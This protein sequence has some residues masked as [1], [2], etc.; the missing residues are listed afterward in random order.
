MAERG[1]TASLLSELGVEDLYGFLGVQS[2]ATEKE[3]GLRMSL[4]V[5]RH[6]AIHTDHQSIQEEGSEVSS[7]QEP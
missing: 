7:R 4:L 5:G 6:L 3:V 2:D 1:K